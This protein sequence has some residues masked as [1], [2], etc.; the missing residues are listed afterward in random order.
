[1]SICTT[2][3]RACIVLLLTTTSSVSLLAEP[4]TGTPKSAD[5]VL[6]ETMEAELTRA[7]SSLGSDANAGLQAAGGNAQPAP[8]PYFLSY[9]V[10]DATSVNMAAAFGAITSSSQSH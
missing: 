10:A 5:K 2:S 8:R 1:M 9:A 6:L 3:I 4:A 7:M